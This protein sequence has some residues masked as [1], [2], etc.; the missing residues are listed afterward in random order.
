M[1]IVRSEGLCQLEIPVT[2]SGIELATFRFVAQRLNHCATLPRSPEAHIVE[3]KR[4]LM[5]HGGAR[6]EK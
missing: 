1:A 6:E 2:Q 4:N 5:A 3:W